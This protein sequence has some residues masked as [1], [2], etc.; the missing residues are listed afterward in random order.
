MESKDQE[1]GK[2]IN[3]YIGTMKKELVQAVF[4]DKEL[5]T[6]EVVVLTGS[7]T[8]KQFEMISFISIFIK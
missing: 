7:L 8:A 2:M 5:V 1:F 3:V 6:Y 4:K